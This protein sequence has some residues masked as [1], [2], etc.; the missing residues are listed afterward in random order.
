M[1]DF[2]CETFIDSSKAWN[3]DSKYQ[4]HAGL[5]HRSDPSTTSQPSVSFKQAVRVRARGS[6][7]AAKPSKLFKT[8][9]IST[10]KTVSSRDVLSLGLLCLRITQSSRHIQKC[11]SICRLDNRHRSDKH[12]PSQYMSLDSAWTFQSKRSSLNVAWVNYFSEKMLEIAQTVKMQIFKQLD[13]QHLGLQWKGFWLCTGDSK[14]HTNWFWC[15][16][17]L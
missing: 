8:V 16:R 17:N 5:S 1:I 12:S 15:P 4:L 13:K 11:C 2:Y 3:N 6:D 7:W 14:F 10:T 9:S